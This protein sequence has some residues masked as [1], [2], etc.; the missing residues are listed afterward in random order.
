MVNFEGIGPKS[1][2]SYR[3]DDLPSI[4]LTLLVVMVFLTACHGKRKAL[5]TI[6]LSQRYGQQVQYHDTLWQ[7]LSLRLD[8]LTVEWQVDSV[9]RTGTLVRAQAEHAVLGTER[10]THTEVHTEVRHR[11]TLATRQERIEPASSESAARSAGYAWLFLLLLVAA[12]LAYVWFRQWRP[13]WWG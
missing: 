10:Q 3:R 9:G 1:P 5:E 11:D 13:R 2:T 6:N 12:L 4:V 8:D 7:M